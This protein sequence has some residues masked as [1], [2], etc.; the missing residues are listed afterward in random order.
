MRTISTNV[1][2]MCY[3]PPQSSVTLS[4]SGG[5][6]QSLKFMRI[7][8][9]INEFYTWSAI[10]SS[11]DKC[12]CAYCN[13]IFLRQLLL[14]ILEICLVNMLLKVSAL[15]KVPSRLYIHIK[16]EIIKTFIEI[17]EPVSPILFLLNRINSSLNLITS[18]KT[19]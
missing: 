8:E 16:D 14:D 6:W 13:E 19:H 1:K 9:H 5:L 2:H 4:N 15:I 3:L 11:S 10:F 12:V 7:Y 18:S 17:L